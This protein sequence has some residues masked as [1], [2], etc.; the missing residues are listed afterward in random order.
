MEE[1][2][3]GEAAAELVLLGDGDLDPLG[4]LSSA[5]KSVEQRARGSLAGDKKR[6]AVDQ[7]VGGKQDMFQTVKQQWKAHTD[8]VMAT[9]ADHTFKIK[10][11]STLTLRLPLV[12]F[13]LL[14]R[15]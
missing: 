10:A 2:R 8:R 15:L 4:A 6:E 1:K 3:E 14:T 5:A 7:S 12:W 9:Y 13:S 11:V